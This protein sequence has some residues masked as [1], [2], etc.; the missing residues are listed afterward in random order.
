[1]IF[2]AHKPWGNPGFIHILPPLIAFLNALPVLNCAL[3]PN[4]RELHRK[5]WL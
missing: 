4:M 2:I 5:Q 1:V 3:L